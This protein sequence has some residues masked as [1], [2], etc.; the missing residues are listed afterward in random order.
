[1]TVDELKRGIEQSTPEQRL[2]LAAYLKHLARNDDPA[3]HAE[4]TRLNK[5]IDEGKKFSL[6][7]VK[8]LHETL[9]REGL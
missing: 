8:H 4:L 1:M 3:Y 5:E 9:K 6:E 7:Q 2:F